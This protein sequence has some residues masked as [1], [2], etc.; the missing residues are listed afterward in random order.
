MV[1]FVLLLSLG[2]IYRYNF[3]REEVYQIFFNLVIL[4]VKKVFPSIFQNFYL[5]FSAKAMI[6]IIASLEV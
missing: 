1:I 2:S 5:F 3:V 4:S 6:Y